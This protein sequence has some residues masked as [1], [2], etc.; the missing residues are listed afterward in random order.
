MVDSLRRMNETRREKS[1]PIGWLVLLMIGS[2]V[3]LWATF[4]GPQSAKLHAEE[5]PPSLQTDLSQE[6]Q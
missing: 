4:F 6:A 2:A 3:A 1:L 5:G